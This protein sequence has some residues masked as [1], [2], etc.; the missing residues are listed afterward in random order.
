MRSGDL[1]V[2]VGD[3]FRRRLACWCQRGAKA[4]APLG[5]ARWRVT[6]TL[7][8]VIATW[9]NKPGLGGLDLP[10]GLKE[11]VLMELAAWAEATFGDLERQVESEVA[12]VLHGAWLR[13][14][15]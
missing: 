2:E 14:V 4:I 15:I 5:A 3:W 7:G 10:L 8:E 6:S 11:A 12:Y 13:S 1:V 9:R